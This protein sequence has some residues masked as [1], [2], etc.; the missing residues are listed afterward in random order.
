MSASTAIGMVSESLF[1]LLDREMSLTPKVPVTVL[2]PDEPGGDRRINLFLYKVIENDILRN[3]DW[4][5]K[6]GDSTQVVPPPLSLNLFYLMTAYC[7][8]DEVSGNAGAHQILG[9]AMRVFYEHAIV[10]QD[11]LVPELQDAKE[12]IKIILNTLDVEELGRVWSTFSQPF[13]LSVLYEVSVVQLDTPSL[14][15]SM[16]PRI[17]Q[18]GTPAINTSF[19]PPVVERLSPISGPVGTEVAIEGQNLI[20]WRAYASILNQRIVNGTELTDDTVTATIPEELS[21]GFYEVRVDIS[22]LHRRVFLFEVTEG[23]A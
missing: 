14:E 5:V 15:R 12:Q 8:N 11:R 10:P 6:P 23:T 17:Q 2:A 7:P 21:P 19:Q 13:R 20:G 18:V 4:Q 9:D 16:A 22:H 3:Q 1:N